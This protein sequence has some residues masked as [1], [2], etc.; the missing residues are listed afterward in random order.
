MKHTYE[1]NLFVWSSDLRYLY[2]SLIGGKK[3]YN[4]LGNSGVAQ[5]IA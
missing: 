4:I 3:S 5:A 1:T 2:W